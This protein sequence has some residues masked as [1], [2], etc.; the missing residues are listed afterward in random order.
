MVT[1]PPSVAGP[2]CARA[3]QVATLLQAWLHSHF[4]TQASDAM[5]TPLK[6]S[7]GP[8]HCDGLCA[9]QHL[10]HL[11]YLRVF[12]F[13]FCLCSRQPNPNDATRQRQSFAALYTRADAS[14][15]M[16][17]PGCGPLH[18]DPGIHRQTN[19]S[20]QCSRHVGGMTSTGAF[21]KWVCPRPKPIA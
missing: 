5:G 8:L 12:C 2:G 7:L 4:C 19:V 18:A 14:A 13:L 17:A 9:V 1:F 3:L 6:G 21:V 11:A 16:R 15:Q 10:W 20:E